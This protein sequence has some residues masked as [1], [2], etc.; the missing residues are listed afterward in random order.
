MVPEMDSSEKVVK[1]VG[2]KRHEQPPPGY[3]EFLPV[4]ILGRLEEFE[5]ARQMPWWTRWLNVCET[6]PV[7][8]GAFGTSVCGLFL[9]GISLSEWVVPRE[10]A[11]VTAYHWIAPT[12]VPAN[13]EEAKLYGRSPASIAV[14]NSGFVPGVSAASPA[15]YTTSSSFPLQPV[16]Y[17]FGR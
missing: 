8:L 13:F 9:L 4:R 7:L 2:W 3:F 11:S 14:I 17:T 15:V 1:L 6:Q 16:G 5:S 10:T 12:E